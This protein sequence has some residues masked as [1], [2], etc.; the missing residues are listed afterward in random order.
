MER[1]SDSVLP[2]GPQPASRRYSATSV[3]NTVF[4][5]QLSK[6]QFQILNSDQTV[7]SSRSTEQH[8]E[9]LTDPR[10]TR[11]RRWSTRG[12]TDQETKT[13]EA[14]LATVYYRSAQGTDASGNCLHPAVDD[15]SSQF[16]HSFSASPSDILLQS[17]GPVHSLLGTGA[18]V[19]DALYSMVV[20]D[21]ACTFQFCNKR[22]SDAGPERS[23]GRPGH[24][25]TRRNLACEK[26]IEDSCAGP[27]WSAGRPGTMPFGARSA[28]CP[29]PITA[30][31]G[32]YG[33][34]PHQ[35]HHTGCN[36][37]EETPTVA[38]SSTIGRQRD[39]P[40]TSQ[41]AATSSRGNAAMDYA[42]LAKVV[43][44]PRRPPYFCGGL[45][46]DVHVWTSIVDRWLNASQGEPSQQMTFVVSLLR[47]AA[48]DW[49]R[50][51]ET[52]TGCP[53]DWTTLRRAMLERFGT[54]IRAEKARSG[55][56]RL[57][58]GN[59]TVLQYSDAFESYL[60][61]IDDYDEA[62]YLV[63]FIF[64]L[65]PEIMRLVYMQQPASLLAAKIMAEKLELTHL[66]TSEPYPSTRKQKTS[67]AQHRGT[68]ERRSGGRHQTKACI[69]VP[70][71]KKVMTMKPA[72]NR[73]CRF[74]HTGATEVSCPGVHGPAAV[75]RSFA[76]DLPRGDRTRYV[77]RQRSVVMIDLEALTHVKEQT[78]AGVTEAKMSM[79]QP[80]VRPKAPRVYLRNRLLRRDRERR[81]RDSVRERQVVTRLL[82]TLVSPE[83]GGTESCQGVTTDDL[84][85]W[86]SIGPT[87]ANLSN[88]SAQEMPQTQLCA[89]SNK[90]QPINPRSKEDGVLMIV[91][92]R[93]FGR[94]VRALID[95]GASRCFISP[96]TVTLCG[97]NVESH[98]TF[99][100]LAD[101][102]K[103]LSRG[104][105]AGVPVVTGGYTVKMNLTVT[106]LLHGADVILG[107]TWLQVADPIIRWS[108]GDV[109]IPDSIS[110]FQRIMGHWLEKQVKTGTV[111]VLST[112]EELNSLRQPSEIASLEILRSPKFW[113]VRKTDDQNSWRSSR[114]LGD[115][116]LTK[117]FEFHHP[118]FGVLKV[119][120]LNN[121]AAL[122]RRSTEGAAGYDLCA[123]HDC[124]IP[125]GGKGLVKTGLSIS[126]PVGLYARIAPRSG[127][128]LKKFI[129]VGAGV[130]DS[131]YRG[132]VGVVLFNHGDQEFQVKMGDRI[133][134]L[135][136]EKIDTPPVEE[137]QGHDSTV[138][139]TGGFG[140]TGVTGKNDTG[141]GSHEKMNELDQN[142]RTVVEGKGMD[143]KNETLKGDKNTGSKMRT[144][145]KSRKTEGTSRLSRERQIIS[146]K[147]LKRLVRKKTPVFLAVV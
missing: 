106:R 119:Q 50:H 36:T 9:G 35:L 109:Y 82:E 70:R 61:Q 1:Q 43:L 145:T 57:R 84:Q 25:P 118:S 90:D 45:D 23:A 32:P 56:Y 21:V 115:R 19:D 39:Q 3:S 55:I 78:P 41:P 104:R 15:H 49:Y 133:A 146:A 120:Q 75:W 87:E 116:T 99:I 14:P 129:D 123:A 18:S 132:D 125:A 97:L 65:R 47:G 67:K 83:S 131:D 96:A 5:F 124:I 112:N 7:T 53:G 11:Q 142:E 107:M 93:I 59:M 71:Q 63:H 139:G 95:S 72:Q 62:Q 144:G 86:R 111:R 114:A 46:E 100:E 60:A 28:A 98:N 77:R 27:D 20:K 147:Q 135:I 54:P 10:T 117:I 2:H 127:L 31:L 34:A 38:S 101:G 128:A 48:Y 105:T 85:G 66:A 29:S 91:P 74:A 140:S 103:V 16:F 88:S 64:G 73:G 89:V 110:S 13:E 24:T 102:K 141:S 134:Q 138:R 40:S 92:A 33:N 37:R 12:T 26:P 51:Y 22:I 122:P 113:T 8:E 121:N 81:T 68:Q 76:K 130:I 79:H 30:C 136:L 44:Q 137:V 126:F 108:T 69:S 80:S 17:V 94:E 42:S 6:N 58:Q 52:R 4:G 143:C